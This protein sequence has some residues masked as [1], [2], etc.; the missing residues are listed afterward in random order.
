MA[1]DSQPFILALAKHL[2]PSSSALRLLDLNGQAGAVL[3]TLRADLVLTA[4]D[5]PALTATPPAANSLDAVVVYDCPLDDNA[6]QVLLQALRPGGRLIRV[7][8]GDVPDES[9]V[10]RLEQQGYTRILVE[11]AVNGRGLLMRGEKPHTEQRT[12]DRI[13]QVAQ[14]DSST[15]L[16]DYRGRYVHLLVR[17]TPN[18]PV[19]ALH[20]D[21]PVQWEAVALDGD[22]P[23]LLAFSSLPKAVAF[24]QPAV[25]AGFI[26]DVN[27]V[28]KFSRE[29]AAAW[30]LSLR[31]NPELADV[32]G[33]SVTLVPVDPAT[34]EAP[35]E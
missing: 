8:P 22:A 11:P 31:F 27:K 15:S 19:W 2:P 13:Q 29:T 7:D 18:K 30:T 25:M 32:T 17:Q 20:E 4:L 21:E 1:S 12:V 26:R 35:D 9:H 6:L 24:M 23:T 10:L 5:L 28:A 3:A 16:A 14:H 34:A 33:A